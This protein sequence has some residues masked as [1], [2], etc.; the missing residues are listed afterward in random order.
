MPKVLTL[1]LL[2]RAD[3]LVGGA[4]GQGN[5]DTWKFKSRSVGRVYAQIIKIILILK[6]QT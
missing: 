2:E 3:V 4:I 5:A 6:G 1:L